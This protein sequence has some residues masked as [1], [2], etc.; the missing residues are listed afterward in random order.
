MLTQ[1]ELIKQI[2]A[3]MGK[4][5]VL[6]LTVLM[7]EHQFPLRALIDITFHPDKNIAFR[8]SWLLENVIIVNAEEHVSDLPYLMQRF[9][10]VSYP[11]SQR[12][13]ANTIIRLTNHRSPEKIKATLAAIDLEAVVEKLFDWLI[14]P[15]VLVA[16]KASA[17]EA[18]LNLSSRYDWIADELA[19]QME[20][21]MRDGTAAIQARG[22]KILHQLRAR[23]TKGNNI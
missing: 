10:E 11:S 4:A 13:Y 16:V 15:K 21:L 3:T 23:K 20:F 8:A 14:D 18:L 19:N 2:S 7:R 12:H 17:A 5:R 6:S 9:P 22:K 1:N